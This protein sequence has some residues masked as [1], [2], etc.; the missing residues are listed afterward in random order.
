MNQ[1]FQQS[2]MRRLLTIQ[3]ESKAEFETG[4]L[5]VDEGDDNQS[6]IDQKLSFR[7]SIPVKTLISKD[8]SPSVI[9]HNF[10]PTSQTFNNNFSFQ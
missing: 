10:N 6:A 5:I 3:S 7:Q 1:I 4:S 8:H 2:H 9:N